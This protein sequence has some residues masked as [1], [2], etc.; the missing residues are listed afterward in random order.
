MRTLRASF[1]LLALAAAAL[2][3]TLSSTLD[4][5]VKDSQGALVPKAEVT[6]TNILTTQT[7]HTITDD[8]GHWVIASLPTG[9]YSVEVSA[10]GFKKA[11]APEV[12]MDA[13]IPAT[14]NVTLEVGAVSETVEVA[15]GAEVLET[16]T[17]TVTTNLSAEQIRDLPIPSRNATDLLMTQPGSQTPAGPRNTTFNGLPQSTINMTLDGINIQDNLLKNGSGGALYPVVYPRL[18]AIEEVSVTTAATGAESLA[19]GGVQI[20]FVTKSG[21]N[22]WHGGAF[23]QERNTALDSNYYFNNIDGL[24]RDRIILHQIGA[25][26]GGPIVK[27]KLFIFF[28]YE[29]FRFPQTWDSGQLAVLTPSAMNGIFTYK[30]TNGIQQI[31]LYQLAAKS[32]FPSTPDP[33]ITNTLQQIGKSIQSGGSLTDRIATNNDYNRSNFRWFPKGEH[34]IDF[35]QGKLDYNITAKHHWEATGTVNP[36]RLFPDGIN[37]V[38]PV[39]PGNGTVLGSPVVVGQREA[40]W[41]GS[42]ALRSAWSAHWTSEIRFGMSSGNVVF[43]DAIQP[44][45][46]A[47]WRGYAPVLNFVQS[48]YRRTTSSRRNNPVQQLMGSANW[49][50]GSH[51]AT[52]GG[53]FSRINEWQQSFSTQTIPSISF[54]TASGDPVNF[55]ATNIFTAANFPGSQNA[56]LTNA[57]SLYA[58]L[59]GRVSSITRSAALDETTHTYGP[60]GAVDRLRQ[61]EFG[62]YAQDSWRVLPKLTINAGI[63][64][65]NQNPFQ[66]LSGT[67]T[68][69]GYAGLFGVSG[70]GNLFKPGTLSGAVPQYFP[71]NSGDVQGYPPTRFWAPTVGIAWVL[72][73]TG[74]P[75]GWLLGHGSQASVLRA[76]FSIA[77]TRGD[78]T[79]I[80]GVWGSNQGRTINTSVDPNNTPAAFGPAGSVLFRDPTLPTLP[81]AATPSYPLPVTAG[82]SV[83]DFD[84]NLKSRYVESW[85]VGFQRS[86]TPDTVL[87]LRYVGNRSA[88]LWSAVNLNEANIVEN[89]FLDQFNIARNNLAIAQQSNPRSVDFGN[90]GLAGQKDVPI[91]KTALGTTSDTNTASLLQ[92]G[93]AGDLAGTIAGNATFMRNLTNAGYPAN[94]FRVNPTTV[95]GGANL[96]TN[97]GGTTY[98]ALQVELR[99]RFT[100]GLLA[101]ASYTWAHSLATGNFL[102]VRDIGGD[103]FTAPSAF[104]NR[105]SIKLNWIYEL[106]VGSKHRALGSVGNPVLRTAVS[107]WQF[108]GVA[109]IQS[110]APAQLTSGRGTFTNGTNGDNGVVLHNLTQA[111]LQDMMSIRKQGNG[112]VLYL[113]QSLIDN[114]L[115]AF[116]L[117]TKT[118]DPSAPYIGPAE[119][120][121]QMGN[122]VYLYNPWLKRAD[123]SLVKKTKIHESKEIEFRV[124]ALNAFNVTDFFLR[125]SGFGNIAVN[126]TGF[127]QTRSAYKDLNSTNDPGSRVIEFALRFTF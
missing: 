81:F 37:N 52:F 17:A 82:N 85:N 93:R 41:S 25:H 105:H 115:A 66:S 107:G 45:L 57:A 63:R 83:N 95:G 59:T 15:G 67:Y 123:L 97:F 53:S 33:L 13:G 30:G 34:K 68:R 84:P 47:Q 64:F 50:H 28:N 51:L 38:L 90:A 40:F 122:V 22:N 39:F 88:R 111:Q 65:E 21:T 55:G 10:P 43:S 125:D 119:T 106:P 8:R 3:Q 79:G 7:F 35:P 48:P 4:G 96:T 116:Q 98:N 86:L 117:N 26:V 19:E 108:S 92:Q 24:P 9:R 42:T 61:W 77:P 71:V 120:P 12:K 102:T 18:D 114:T 112:I 75:L 46:F 5:L 14:V 74:G 2:C 11:T 72:P 94:L 101:G 80:T 103:G 44:P 36:Y 121:G 23:I 62:L 126:S 56:D 76:G 58:M 60:Y 124:N 6:V 1:L 118:L 127:G 109:R 100:R 89:G 27:N 32:R 29:V 70:V 104:D 69:P 49:T 54:A 31:D 73:Q 87:E 113:P 99:R 91:L 110:G 20:K 78:F 16:T